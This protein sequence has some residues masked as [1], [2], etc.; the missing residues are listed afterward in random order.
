M[1]RRKAEDLLVLHLASGL[2]VQAAAA[3]AGV[4]R[5]TAF[6]RLQDKSFR[7]RVSQ[8]RADLLDR[9][10]GYLVGASVKAAKTLMRLLANAEAKVKL[11]A[12]KAILAA[13]INIRGAVELEERLAALEAEQ[14]AK[15]GPRRW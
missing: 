14:A 13:V 5:A 1:A 15:K 7:Q 11:Q 9:T 2:T 4:S 3:K 8:A 12:A 10:A 6:R